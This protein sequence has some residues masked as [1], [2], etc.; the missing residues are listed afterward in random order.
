[1][2]KELR[3]QILAARDALLPEQRRAKSR[4]IEERLFALPEFISARTIMFFASFRSEVETEPMI[5]RA[6]HSGK[7]IILPKVRGK[8]LSLFE[9]KDFDRDLVPGAW[10]IP[11]PCEAYPAFLNDVALIIVPGAAFD[12][13]GNRIGYGAGFYDKLLPV[14]TKTTVALAFELQIVANVPADSH[15]IP[16]QKIVTENRVITVQ[17][18]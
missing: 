12:E 14:F 9:I 7:R 2:K 13:W 4:E 3:K 16:V 10:G 15:D 6:L 18:A 5:R 17:R 8:E 1:M 11:E